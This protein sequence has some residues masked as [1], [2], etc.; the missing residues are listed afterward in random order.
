M[1]SQQ[2]VADLKDA[3]EFIGFTRLRHQA[4]LIRAGKPADNYVSPA[5][6]SS[7]DRSYL[8]SAFRT[9]KTMQAVM[10]A[11]YQTGHF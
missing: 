10:A 8:K 5:D 11:R 6:L 7:R 3:L 1:L 9:V 2:G 4:R